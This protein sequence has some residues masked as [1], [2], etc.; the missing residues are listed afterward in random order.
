MLMNSAPFFRR[1]FFTSLAVFAALFC[2][3]VLFAADK[4]DVRAADLRRIS[5]L[6][7]GDRATLD[8][9]LDDSLT[10]G[11]ADGRV[12]TKAELL[13]ALSSG[14]VTYHSYDGPPPTVRV[15]GGIALLSGVAELQA[16]ARGTRVQLS[17][18]YLAVYA[19]KES[20]WRLIAYQSARIDVVPVSAR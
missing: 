20:A 6:I 13:A 19:R 4:E 5:A 11:H 17:L 9:V 15:E 12:Q 3:S 7:N 2:G 8:A 16:S 1:H 14:A 18:R 10:Y